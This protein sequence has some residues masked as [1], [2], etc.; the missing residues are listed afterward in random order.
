MC[1]RFTLHD[2]PEEI[3]A[4]LDDLDVDCT[5]LEPFEPCYNVAPTT[6]AP[7][8]AGGDTPTAGLRR[9]GLVPHWA[10]DPSLGNRMINARSETVAEKPSFRDAY[11]RRRCFIF[12]EMGKA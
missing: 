7:T 5:G 8:V 6:Y 9:W 10:K 3:I 11:R 12:A 1:G 4:S 2:T